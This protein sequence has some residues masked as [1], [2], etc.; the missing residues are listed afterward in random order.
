MSED[1]C[2]SSDLFVYNPHYV[3][4]IT[5]RY[6]QNFAYMDEPAPGMPVLFF[7]PRG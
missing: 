5:T 1:A 3:L 6:L 2:L 7:I 4:S